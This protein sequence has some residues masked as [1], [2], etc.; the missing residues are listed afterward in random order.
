MAVLI[1]A[2]LIGPL[3]V[4]VCV[5]SSRVCVALRLCWGLCGCVWCV[6]PCGSM[7]IIWGG[8]TVLSLSA[9]QSRKITSG[10][11]AQLSPVHPR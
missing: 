10:L 6:C 4:G 11:A 1:Y 3:C 9:H 2:C 8:V 7:D 5:W